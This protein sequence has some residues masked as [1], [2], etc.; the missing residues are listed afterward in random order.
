MGGSSIEN[1]Y[2]ELWLLWDT[3]SAPPSKFEE[4]SRI[5]T[6]ISLKFAGGALYR[7]HYI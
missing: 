7:D 1:Q 3:L 5:Y 6:E 4:I 2:T